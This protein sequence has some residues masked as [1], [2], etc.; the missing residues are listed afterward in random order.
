MIPRY[1][2]DQL[3]PEVLGTIEGKIELIDQQ[4]KSLGIF[5]PY[6]RNNRLFLVPDWDEAEWERKRKLPARPLKDIWAKLEA[7]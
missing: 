3:T 4:G 7:L 1:R 5:T 2:E 6:I